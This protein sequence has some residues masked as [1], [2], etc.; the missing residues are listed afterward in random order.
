MIQ[1]KKNIYQE[2]VPERAEIVLGADIGGTNSNFGISALTN[3]NVILL[4]SIHYKTKEVS[5]F[6]P[7]IQ[8]VLDE[9][10][11]QYG[12]QIRR[13]CFAGAGIVSEEQD[14]VK[15]TN[16]P[17]H[18]DAKNIVNDTDL[19]TA[20]IIND[21]IAVGYGI[22][23]IDS[24]K[25]VKIN[26]NHPRNYSNRA[27]IGAGTGLGKAI[28]GW[29]YYLEKYIPISSEGGHADFPVFTQKEFDLRT[30][31]QSTMEKKCPVSWEDVLSGQGI[32]RIYSFLKTLNDY[33]QTEFENEIN[34]SGL[35]PDVIFSYANKDKASGDTYHWYSRFYARCAKDFALDT[36]AL[37][38]VYIAGGIAEKN[39]DLFRLPQFMQ[40]FTNCGK[41][42]EALKTIPIWIITDYNVSLY[43]AA[44]YLI[45]N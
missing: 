43:G 27:I 9:V 41:Q 24:N 22:D 16:V 8:D 5:S 34:K 1:S 17:L 14:F 12:Y 6:P 35:H 37:G 20:V 19:E 15:L 10:N 30:Y 38:G 45:Q 44:A 39:I 3:S 25:L 26:N 28:L 13:G 11:K 31:I 29:D 7:I 4:M 40:E 18:L 21:F 2:E 23:H 33:K 36:L 32:V 42:Q